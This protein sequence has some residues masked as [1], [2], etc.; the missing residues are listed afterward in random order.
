MTDTPDDIQ[1]QIDQLEVMRGTLGDA[2]VDD[3]IAKLQAKLPTQA[4]TS[5]GGA[6]ERAVLPGQ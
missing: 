4:D 5:C 1:R 6:K 2:M 3:A